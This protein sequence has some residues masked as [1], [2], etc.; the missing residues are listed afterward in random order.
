MGKTEYQ[1]NKQKQPSNLQT[2]PPLSEV[3]FLLYI[4]C[5]EG[6]F[7]DFYKKNMI[8]KTEYQK[9]K[10]KQ[11]SNFHHEMKYAFCCIFSVGKVISKISTK[12]YD[13][14]D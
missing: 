3:H 4:Q 9:T 5:W 6:H 8:S 14:Q 12:T 7:K 2:F 13:R 10:Q 11:S 1:K